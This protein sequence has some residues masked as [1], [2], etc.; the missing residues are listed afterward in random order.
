MDSIEQLFENNKVW[1]QKIKQEQPGF[2]DK[3]A[4]QQ[5][6][7]YL[8]IGCSDSRVPAN[9]LLGMLPGEVFVHRN[10]ANQVV[11]SDLNCLSVIQFAV[12]VLKVK[13]V[14]VCG[15]Y[16]CGG[17]AASLDQSQNRLIDN[18]LQ[19]IADVYR[20]NRLELDNIEDNTERQNRLSELNVIEQVY[21]VT[22]TGTLK[23]AW[24]NGQ[25]VQV[26]GFIYNV[27]DGVLKNLNVS[28]SQNFD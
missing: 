19:H 3:L 21:N 11:H 20:H 13:H 10:I 15:H 14:I 9:E 7:E 26:H 4:D 1:A 12:E 28:V 22:H 2:F 17:V 8:W 16:G 24:T 23:R 18:W 5:A 25:A 27:K 6:P